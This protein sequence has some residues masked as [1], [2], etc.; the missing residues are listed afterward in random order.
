MGHWYNSLTLRLL[1]TSEAVGNIVPNVIKVLETSYVF[2]YTKIHSLE[3]DVTS[4]EWKHFDLGAKLADLT[5]QPIKTD[6]AKLREVVAAYPNLYF[7]GEMHMQ[8]MGTVQRPIFVELSFTQASSEASLTYI[9]LDI[10]EHFY[11][12]IAPFN[13]KT[14]KFDFRYK[15]KEHIVIFC[16]DIMQAANKDWLI[17]TRDTDPGGSVGEDSGEYHQHYPVAIYQWGKDY[18]LGELG[19]KLGRGDSIG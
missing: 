7:S 4:Q 9:T 14:G 6:L 8:D 5:P 11:D 16:L 1:P 13:K 12:P 18:Q 10:T 19:V 15:Y 3:Y 2:N 17:T